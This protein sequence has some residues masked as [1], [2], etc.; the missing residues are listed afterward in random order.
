[1]DNLYLNSDNTV[2]V[3]NLKNNVTDTI[4]TTATV[5]VTVV[6]SDGVDIAGVTWPI[7]LPH[8]AD[9]LYRGNLPDTLVL[10]RNQRV[11][12]TYVA[13]DGPG[14]HREWCVVYKVVCK[15]SC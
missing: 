5:T 12:A 15:S 8:I 11:Y 13:D 6:D 14:F 7:S 2:E 4:I 1:M 10:E 9:G 3:R